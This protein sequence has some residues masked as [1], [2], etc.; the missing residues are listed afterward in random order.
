MPTPTTIASSCSAGTF[1]D[2]QGNV[3]PGS[4]TFD[5][6]Q[7]AAV[8]GGGEVVPKRVTITVDSTGKPS[9]GQSIWRNTDLTPSGTTYRMQFF[10]SSGNFIADFGS[11]VISGSSPIDLTLLT[12]T[13]TSGG[14]TGF[15]NPVLQ[16]PSAPQVI[17]GQTLSLSNA[18]LGFEASGTTPDTGISRTAAATIAIGNGSQG[19]KTGILQL[20]SIQGPGIQKQIFTSNGTFTIPT[21]ITQVKVMAIGGGGGGAGNTGGGGASGGGGG[22]CAIKWLTGLT[23]GNTLAVV[24]GTGGNGGAA[25]A[26]N[27]ISGNNSSVASGTQT[28]STITANGGT[29]GITGNAGGGA[30]GT[31]SGGDL[32]IGGGGGGYGYITTGNPGGHGGSSFLAGQTNDGSGGPGQSG[33]LYGGGGAGSDAVGNQPGGN[34]AAGIVV[35]E[36]VN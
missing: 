6:S 2:A 18:L 15:V 8:T 11:Q 34:G 5:L 25:G 23:P 16:N 3:I 12:P 13:T 24:V 9:S 35:F 20:A 14:T 19:N 4:L 33:Q 1:Q 10:D 29:N 17:T 36:W 30:G 22:G 28:I 26:N 32:N 21:G 7:T 31:A 27:G